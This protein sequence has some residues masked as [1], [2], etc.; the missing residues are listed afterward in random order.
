MPA[1]RSAISVVHSAMA[2]LSSSI[3]V[4]DTS[5]ERS[6]SFAV[7]SDLSS[8]ASQYFFFWS[9]PA[10]S[11]FRFVIISSI[12]LITFSKPCALPCSAS[13][14]RSRAE[15]PRRGEPRST[16]SARARSARELSW[17]CTRLAEGAGNVFLNNSRASSALRTLMVSASASS[18]SARTLHRASHSAV[19]VAQPFCSSARYFLSSARVSFVSSRSLLSSATSTLSSPR[20]I[21]SSSI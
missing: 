1:L 4:V 5:I 14:T 17:I 15:P 2:P 18:S 20:R 12:S 19:L 13:I 21:I 16:A 7:S 6:S 11:A 10:C 3:A 8:S 9:S